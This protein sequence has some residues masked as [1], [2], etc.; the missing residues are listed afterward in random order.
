MAHKENALLRAFQ[1]DKTSVADD[2]VFPSEAGTPQ[3]PEVEFL[4]DVQSKEAEGVIWLP[5]RDRGKLEVVC[6]VHGHSNLI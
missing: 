4:H 2:L 5:P 3:E 1:L 6:L